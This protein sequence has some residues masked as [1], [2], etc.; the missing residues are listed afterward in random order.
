MTQG[1]LPAV[2]VVLSDAP[3]HVGQDVGLLLYELVGRD[4]ALADATAHGAAHRV[5][6]DT[7]VPRSPDG[8][9]QPARNVA[10]T[11]DGQVNT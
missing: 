1:L 9:I 7:D 3:A 6:P 8:V 10:I 11:K 5:E 2:V 4:A